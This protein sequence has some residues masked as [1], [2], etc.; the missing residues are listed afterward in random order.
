MTDLIHPRRAQE[1]R[2]A[3]THHAA[4][5]IIT[6]IRAGWDPDHYF[7]NEAERDLILEEVEHIANELK[8]RAI[9][10]TLQPCSECD[11]PYTVNA[12][13]T[14][15]HHHGIAPNGYSTGERCPGVGEPP[16][17]HGKGAAR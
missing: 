8:A 4:M 9:V 10:G 1:L 17:G 2:R 5:I 16:R 3:A 14:I 13:G 7:P 11:F 6:A 15:R 12:D